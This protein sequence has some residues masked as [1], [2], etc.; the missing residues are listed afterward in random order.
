MT[1]SRTYFDPHTLA[2]LNGLQLRARHLVEGFVAG[3]HRSPWKGFSVEFAEHREYAPGDDLRYVDWKV[4]GRTG[5]HYVKQFEDE[6]NLVAYL[7]L[8]VSESM[9]YRGPAAAMSKLEYAQLLLAA[10]GWLVLKQQDAVALATFDSQVR[11]ALRPSSDATQTQGLVRLLE[12]AVAQAKEVSNFATALKDLAARWIKRGVVIIAT[13]AFAEVEV[14]VSGLAALVA[15]KHDVILW[16]VLDR[17]EWEFPFSGPL[18][19]TGLEALA[20]RDVDGDHVRRAYQVQMSKHQRQLQARCGSMGVEMVRSFSD[21]PVDQVL[22]QLLH[23]RL[24]R[25]T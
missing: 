15:R 20:T 12:E 4:Y 21:E 1:V 9:T 3:L 19:V 17:A 18:R 8:D 23:R 24:A 16:Q 11:A 7:A 5:K 14:I 10:I 13:D 6:T 25:N 2:R 22:S